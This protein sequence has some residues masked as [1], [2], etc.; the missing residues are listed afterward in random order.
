LFDY[1]S[2]SLAAALREAKEELVFIL[3]PQKGA[4]QSPALSHPSEFA[5]DYC[6]MIQV[7]A[8]QRSFPVIVIIAH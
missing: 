8:Q 3:D 5:G 6:V 2:D 1:E 4:N 7:A